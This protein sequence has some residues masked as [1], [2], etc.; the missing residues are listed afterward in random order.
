MRLLAV[1]SIILL[2]ALTGCGDPALHQVSGKVTLGGKPYERLLVYFHPLTRE[3]SIFSIGVGE[4]S[5]D[6]TLVLRSTAGDGL[7]SGKYRVSFAC[8]VVQGSKNRTV[9]LEDDKGDD[10]RQLDTKDIVPEPYNSP[11]ESP[12]EFEIKA[13]VENIFEFD[14]PRS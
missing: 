14:I 5:K 3:P 1:T 4:T 2:T 8:Y 6:G 12:V 7:A 11:Q 10:K 13:G 9:G